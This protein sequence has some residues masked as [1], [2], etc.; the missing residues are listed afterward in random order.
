MC[1]LKSQIPILGYVFLWMASRNHGIVCSGR[2]NDDCRFDLFAA[3]MDLLECCNAEYLL[4]FQVSIAGQPY[5]VECARQQIRVSLIY[6]K[7]LVVSV[8]KLS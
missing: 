1:I 7:P 4:L 2:L 5:G 6:K 3:H 8:G